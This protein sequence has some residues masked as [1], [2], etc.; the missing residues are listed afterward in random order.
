MDVENNFA[1]DEA[2]SRFMF[3]WR[4]NSHHSASWRRRS[5]MRFKS[6]RAGGGGDRGLI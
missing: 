5:W 2:L 3:I 4:R 1:K 6:S